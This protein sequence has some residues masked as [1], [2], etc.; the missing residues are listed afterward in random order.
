MPWRKDIS[1]ETDTLINDQ[2]VT[3]QSN[4]GD[5]VHHVK[6]YR[7]SEGEHQGSLYH[8]FFYI[9]GNSAVNYHPKEYKQLRKYIE[10]YNE[11]CEIYYVD[12]DGTTLRLCKNWRFEGFR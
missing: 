8:I 10:M 2:I 3:I 4:G 11:D 1:P 9:K 12:P 7:M 6:S 5:S